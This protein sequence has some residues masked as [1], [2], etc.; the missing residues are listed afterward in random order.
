M[1]VAL[2]VTVSVQQCRTP[3]HLPVACSCAT[4]DALHAVFSDVSLPGCMVDLRAES[5]RTGLHLHGTY[6]GEVS[7]KHP[8]TPSSVSGFPTL[9]PTDTENTHVGKDQQY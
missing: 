1:N 2:S 4:S 3:R 9:I 8:E 6:S 5:D 7:H